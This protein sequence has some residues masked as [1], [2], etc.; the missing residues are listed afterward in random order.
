[1]SDA[2]LVT[3]GGGFVGAAVVRRLA[4]V[5]ADR[6]LRVGGDAI[7][8]HVVALLRPG[9]SRERLRDLPPEGPWSVR[10]ADLTRPDDVRALFEATRPVA[11]IHTA[12]ERA[13]FA[14]RWE[15]QH[16][17]LV[18][19]PLEA[20]VAG[21]ARA[22]GGRLV[23]T[24]SAWVLP[25]GAAL[26]EDT[27]EQ[28][29]SPYARAK[30]LED[31]LLPEVAERHG[32]EWLN[33]RL[34]NLYGRYERPE[35]LIPYLVACLVHGE[36]ADLSDGNHIRDFTDVDLVSEAY[37]R[38]LEVPPGAAG[39]L[40]HIGTGRGTSIRALASVVAEV[41]GGAH[42]LRFG[43]KAT[44]DGEV[45]VQVANIDRARRALGWDPPDDLAERVRGVT[46]WWLDRFGSRSGSGAIRSEGVR[47]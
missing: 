25:G 5:L 46:R 8:R 1:M 22:G 13:A 17:P 20:V 31:R 9:G 11:V 36:P 30:A 34:F 44:A 16:E 40:Y 27:A 42:L 45:P 39:R 26:D 19:V 6:P 38:A 3:G 7:A 35:R 23:H 21:L 4:A 32:I 37:V 29:A 47:T 12:L 10:E 14:E 43:R 28:P 2:I 15:Q 33:L 18:R 41:T 24:G